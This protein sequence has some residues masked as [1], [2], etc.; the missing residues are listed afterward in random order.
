MLIVNHHTC[1]LSNFADTKY[2]MQLIG[3]IYDC[4]P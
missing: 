2:M 3:V 4:L 1:F